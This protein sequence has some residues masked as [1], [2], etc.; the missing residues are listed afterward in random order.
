[1]TWCI[2]AERDVVLG[3][4]GEA[5]GLAALGENELVSNPGTAFLR[6]DK[7]KE[8]CEFGDW[9]GDSMGLFILVGVGMPDVV[10]P[11]TGPLDPAF[12]DAVA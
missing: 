1:M 7:A 8:R 2:F 5:G 3:N 6:E 10:D 11:A 9:I 12:A 4:L